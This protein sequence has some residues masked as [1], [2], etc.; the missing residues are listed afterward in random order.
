M[1]GAFSARRSTPSASACSSR[2]R[3]RRWTASPSNS[4]P[5]SST[6][7]A[8]AASRRLGAKLDG[9]PAPPSA[10][11]QR[12]AA[13]H[14]RL[15]HHRPE[16]P[17]VKAHL[18]GSSTSRAR[19]IAARC[20]HD[21]PQAL[22]ELR[23][24]LRRQRAF[25]RPVRTARRHR[26]AA[27]G[28]L[29]RELLQR[30]VDVERG[31]LT[32]ARALLTR[33]GAVAREYVE[34]GGG[35]T[36]ARSRPSA[37]SSASPR[38][39]SISGFQLL[40]QDGLPAERANLIQPP[41]QPAPARATAAAPAMCAIRV[42]LS[43]PHLGRARGCAA[44]A[45][46]P[47]GVH[48]SRNS[49]DGCVCWLLVPLPLAGRRRSST[50]GR[51]GVP[52]RSASS[53]RL[54]HRRDRTAPSASRAA[55]YLCR[56]RRVAGTR[57]PDLRNHLGNHGGQDQSVHHR[58]PGIERLGAIS[59]LPDGAQAVCTRRATRWTRTR[60]A[61]RCGCCPPSAVRGG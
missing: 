50:P 44:Y 43:A 8:G 39:R 35:A 46:R 17:T 34:A 24:R 7:R 28:D 45:E 40:A 9:I 23:H 41:L 26:P 22:P 12:H 16:W 61:R 51:A 30:F 2:T 54:G 13:R 38:R 15:Q 32:F 57:Y 49:R 37:S 59:P 29:L 60:R 18:T 48:L 58:R 19:D 47:R 5:T 20:M 3:S 42:P 33:P 1:R 14:L 10:R 56:R 27:P 31:P 21:G 52:P 36:T 53:P 25:L 6:S 4:V 55:R 11:G